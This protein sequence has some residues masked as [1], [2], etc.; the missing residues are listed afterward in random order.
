MGQMG[1]YD[2]YNRLDA[3]SAKGD[4]LARLSRVCGW[5]LCRVA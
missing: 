4:P 3:I 5:S 2:F 1:F